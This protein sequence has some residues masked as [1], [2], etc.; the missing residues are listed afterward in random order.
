MSSRSLFRGRCVVRPGGCLV[1]E[2][3]GFEAA[4]L[5]ADEPAG[6]LAQGGAVLVAAGALAV[7]AGAG[8]GEE[9]SVP[10]ATVRS[11]RCPPALVTTPARYRR[12]TVS[13]STTRA[14]RQVKATS[15]VIS[16]QPEVYMHVSALVW[17]ITLVTMIVIF[18]VDLLIVGMRKRSTDMDGNC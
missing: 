7:V 2:G 18:A 14:R 5:D 9:G 3:A 8:S 16:C 11:A 12:S 15:G 13:A 4:V 6:E 10:R 17:A 1:V